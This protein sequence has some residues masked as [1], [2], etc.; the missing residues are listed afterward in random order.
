MTLGLRQLHM[1]L[2]FEPVP[3]PS[4]RPRPPPW[5]MLHGKQRKPGSE[6][7]LRTLFPLAQLSP[8]KCLCRDHL[9]GL[10]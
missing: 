3:S 7:L 10:T 8:R 6:H 4:Q 1:F 9:R 2:V 5:E